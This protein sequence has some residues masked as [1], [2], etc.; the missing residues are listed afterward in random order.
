MGNEGVVSPNGLEC[1]C[2]GSRFDAVGNVTRGPASAP[3]KH[4]DVSADA[5]GNLTVHTG[6]TVDAARLNV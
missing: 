6:S 5:Q 2:H 4:F 3:L 1:A